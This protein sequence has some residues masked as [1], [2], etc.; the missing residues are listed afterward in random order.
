LVLVGSGL[1]GIG[2]LG[3]FRRGRRRA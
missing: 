1:I 3:A 2:G